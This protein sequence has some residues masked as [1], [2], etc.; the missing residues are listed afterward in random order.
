MKAK[1]NWT[2]QK[3]SEHFEICIRTL[4]RW[5]K[6]IETK[7]HKPHKTKID[8]EA[9]KKDVELYPDA[10]QYERGIRLG[11]SQSCILKHLKKLKISY[12]KK[13]KTSKTR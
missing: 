7:K 4:F 6:C 13:S 8:I 5:S 1:N 9:L 2:F 3:T 11:V 10:Y 12:K